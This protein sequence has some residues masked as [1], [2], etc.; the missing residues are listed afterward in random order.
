MGDT[1]SARGGRKGKESECVLHRNEMANINMYRIRNFLNAQKYNN[2]R[3]GNVERASVR[4]KAHDDEKASRMKS[5]M[6]GQVVGGRWYKY[7]FS[8]TPYRSR[9]H[10]LW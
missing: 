8:P 2:E 10:G 9:R 5:E 4:T 1:L 7:N 6:A 3:A